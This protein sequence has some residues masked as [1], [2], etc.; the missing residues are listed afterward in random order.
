MPDRAGYWQRF[1]R[2]R[3]SR[4]RLLGRGAAALAGLLAAN[5]SGRVIWQPRPLAATGVPQYG[6]R[7][8]G[9]ITT[10][11]TSLDPH[12]SILALP[13]AP[14]LYNALVVRSAADDS[15]LLNDLAEAYEQPDETTYIFTI[16]PG[17]RI[18]PNSLGVPERDLDSQDALATFERLRGLPE[19]IP[20]ISRRFVATWFAS[21][22]AP[23]PATYVV[24]TPS[25]YAYFLYRLG[26][27]AAV[28][29]PRELIESDSNPMMLAAV[30]GGPFYVPPGGLN[31][32]GISL[33][34]N[35]NYYRRDAA[36]GGAQLPYVD[37]LDMQ[38]IEDSQAQR[39]EAFTSRNLDWYSAGNHFD[40]EDLVG[41][42]NVYDIRQPDFSFFSFVMN[43]QRP[44]WNDPRIRRA[45]MYA[46]NR[47]LFV[48]LIYLGDAAPN[49]LVPWPLGDFALPPDELEQL[50]PYDPQR[51]RDLIQEATGGETLSINI[52]FPSFGNS[53]VAADHALLLQQ[54]FEQVGFDVGLTAMDL[55][56]WLVDITQKEYD[57][58]LV[59]NLP[60]ET[61]EAPL[62][63]HHSLGP[64]GDGSFTNDLNDPAIDAAI[65]AAR[66]IQNR[67]ELVEAVRGVQRQI[68]EAA[69]TCL[70][71]VSAW[72]HTLYWKSVRNVRLD[73]GS[74][75]LF[76]NDFW[77]QGAGDAK[78]TATHLATASATP[79]RTRTPTP[80]RTATPTPS[81][82]LRGD[83]SCDGDVNSVDAALVLQHNAGLLQRLPC[84]ENADVN[85]DGRVNAVDAAL[86][87]QYAAGIVDRFPP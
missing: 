33:E 11:H 37:G 24:R 54:Q 12:V 46:M 62:D 86:I 53:T 71:I 87:L 51:A 69:P 25:P 81:E 68:Y 13:L 84:P 20:T 26:S 75:H 63:F 32:G 49:G 39:R 82:Q 56:L 52:K 18:A 64:R 85:R 7:L 29:P 59:P 19:P 47:S 38:L 27:A 73:P 44:P 6:G 67:A 17:V 83:A 16:R 9:A 58:T 43:I 1:A 70:P 77:I 14:R 4:R 78:P 65:D 42:Y 50:Q 28:I 48:P 10:N 76:R 74:A 80:R 61:P 34:R 2:Q 22:E 8:R 72:R 5:G 3:I 40:A 31:E 60:N 23:S 36:N 66:S 35:P 79:T 41:D 21:H 55:V 15:F 30:G 45:A 57:A